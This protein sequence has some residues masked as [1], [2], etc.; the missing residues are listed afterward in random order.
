MF[1]VLEMQKTGDQVATLVNSYAEL[2]KAKQK[3]HQVLAA[4]AVSAVP[5]HTAVILEEFG[6]VLEY[7]HFEH[8]EE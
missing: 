1:I 5:V 7:E 8:E 3:Y 4:A 2:N 6:N